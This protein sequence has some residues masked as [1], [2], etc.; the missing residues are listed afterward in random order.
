MHDAPAVASASDAQLIQAVARGEHA[1]IETLYRSHCDALLR[2]V[3]RRLP[4][5]FEDA[6]EITHDTF[7]T[8]LKLAA[9]YHGDSS[10]LAWL[11]G[12]ARLRITD[13]H[14]RQSREKR[15][16]REKLYT[17]DEARDVALQSP[18][19][20]DAREAV[21]MLMRGLT[22]DEREAMTLRYV[23]ELPVRE[24]AT[25]LGRT[26][27]AIENLL[28]RAKEKQRK[29]IMVAAADRRNGQSQFVDG[30]FDDGGQP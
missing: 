20:I 8:A 24:I 10:P 29:S 14:R 28:L 12:I 11:Y 17:L 22:E 25:I 19:G 16:P 9:T 30:R 27:K 23:E 4:H 5:S 7:L 1:A 2:F 26:E 13:H 21:D 15:V 6:Q 18:P 3:Y